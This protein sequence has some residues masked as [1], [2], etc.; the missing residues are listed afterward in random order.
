MTEPKTNFV[1]MLVDIEKFCTVDLGYSE[2]QAKIEFTSNRKVFIWLNATD[3]FVE[4]APYEDRTYQI[5]TYEVAKSVDEVR[6]LIWNYLYSQ[7]K[8][9]DER[10]LAFALRRM[11]TLAGTDFAT[12]VG[13][14]IAAR[15][16]ESINEASNLL[17]GPPAGGRSATAAEVAE[18]DELPF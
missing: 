15:M 10:E 6:D 9:R 13:R 5:S 12:A 11:A 7:T 4:K 17:T 8:R 18:L 3:K 1:Q 16:K 14:F 2:A